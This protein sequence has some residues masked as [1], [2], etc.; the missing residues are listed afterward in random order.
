MSTPTWLN[1]SPVAWHREHTAPLSDWQQQVEH[2][3][4]P[5]SVQRKGGAGGGGRDWRGGR[6]RSRWRSER[7]KSRGGGEGV[8]DRRGGK[9]RGRERWKGG[10]GGWG[11]RDEGVQK[12]EK[13]WELGGEERDWEIGEE[14]RESE[15]LERRRRRR[16][17]A[18]RVYILSLQSYFRPESRHC[19]HLQVSAG[20]TYYQDILCS[21]FYTIYTLHNTPDTHT[22]T[23]THRCTHATVTHRWHWGGYYWIP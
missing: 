19:S 4:T 10:R 6:R 8:I 11:V 9:R 18:G 21:T 23:Q 22:H 20:F 17:K 12:A 5:C 15:R 2:G 14:E 16:R 3:A 7:L 13:E 1:T